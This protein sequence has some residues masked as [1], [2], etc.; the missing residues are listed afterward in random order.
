MKNT[1]C[2]R[3]EEIANA[4]SKADAARMAPDL[5]PADRVINDTKVK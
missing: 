1:T 2:L 4:L 3:M 5:S